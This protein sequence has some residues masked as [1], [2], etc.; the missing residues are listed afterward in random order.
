M[1]KTLDATYIRILENIPDAAQEVAFT[2]LRWITYSERPLSLAELVDTTIITIEGDSDGTVDRG[3]RGQWDDALHLLAGLIVTNRA[4]IDDSPQPS[5]DDPMFASSDDS[6]QASNDVQ[7][8]H[9]TDR[10]SDQQ[11]QLEG[12]P[13]DQPHEELVVSLVH[14]SLQEYLESSRIQESSVMGYGLHSQRDHGCLAQSCLVYLKYNVRNAYLDA[15]SDQCNDFN[16]DQS[17]NSGTDDSDRTNHGHNDDPCLAH[18]KQWVSRLKMFPLLTYAVISWRYHSKRQQRGTC[19]REI[20]LL[21]SRFYLCRLNELCLLRCT[22]RVGERPRGVPLAIE[23][24]VRF[25]LED[26][27]EKLL[28]T[29]ICTAKD[30]QRICKIAIEK[31]DANVFK[32]L[33]DRFSSADEWTA[34]AAITAVS[35]NRAEELGYLLHANDV[36]PLCQADYQVA[37]VSQYGIGDRT[38]SQFRMLCAAGARTDNRRGHPVHKILVDILLDDTESLKLHLKDVI[39]PTEHKYA[40]DLALSLPDT[41]CLTLL[42]NHGI[43]LEYV[44]SDLVKVCALSYTRDANVTKE[45]IDLLL[46]KGATAYHVDSALVEVCA[47]SLT[48]DSDMTRELVQL[49]LRNG[50]SD[51]YAAVVKLAYC[52]QSTALLNWLLEICAEDFEKAATSMLKNE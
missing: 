14:F 1:P 12:N 38:Q 35:M 17:D 4:S 45:L 37:M 44:N 36:N 34:S 8:Q 18:S 39:D 30:Q 15:V 23:V 19:H 50:A 49:L 40:Y 51:Y 47:S 25:G 48:R 22:C 31:G 9:A 42:L 33:C 29:N 3:D 20:A 28:A 11:T 41:T 16:S 32:I 26:T 27:V 10:I 5:K 2:L 21:T 24:A 13:F 7:P 52:D 6:S 43:G 46:R